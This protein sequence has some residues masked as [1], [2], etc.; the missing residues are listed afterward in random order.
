MDTFKKVKKILLENLG[1]KEEDIKLESNLIEDLG[2][3]SLDIVELCLALEENFEI[4]VEDEDFEQLKTLGSIIAYIDKESMIIVVDC[5][6][7][8]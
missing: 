8:D 7:Q 6:I 1:C 4:I 3:D 5:I 2:A